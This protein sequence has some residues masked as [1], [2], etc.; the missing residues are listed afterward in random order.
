[1]RDVSLHLITFN[2]FLAVLNAHCDDRSP[3]NETAENNN[4]PRC[5]PGKS[6]VKDQRNQFDKNDN[7]RSL[8]RTNN[9]ND[10]KMELNSTREPPIEYA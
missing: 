5:A 1:M 7:E 8:C 6:S 2:Q 9:D 10:W 3:L 4:I